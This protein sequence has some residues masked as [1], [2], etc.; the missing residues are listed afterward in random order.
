MAPGYWMLF[1][2]NASGVHSVA[3]IIQVSLNP[4]VTLQNPGNQQSVTGDTILLPVQVSAAPGIA[5]GYSATGLPAGLS[6]NPNTGVISG[7]LT[8]APGDYLATVTV[9]PGVGVP[10]STS[11][12]WTVLA[13][14]PGQGKL[15]HEWWID[16]PGDALTSILRTTPPIRRISK[17][18]PS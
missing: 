13:P 2:L 18:V 6:S 10:L 15:L 14:N 7:T 11:F 4:D 5:L 12:N 9:T 17:A 3:K 8:A 16:I 1:G